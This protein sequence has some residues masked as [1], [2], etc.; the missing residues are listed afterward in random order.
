MACVLLGCNVEE[1]PQQQNGYDCGVFV[2]MFANL[3]SLGYPLHF[4]QEHATMYRQMMLEWV[5]SGC[6]DPQALREI[7]T[8]HELP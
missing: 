2:C 8:L 5:E 6:T 1:T 7:H 3:L 4:G